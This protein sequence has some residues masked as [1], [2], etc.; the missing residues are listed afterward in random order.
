MRIP[1]YRGIQQKNSVT[2]Q[3]LTLKGD[4]ACARLLHEK[5][6]TAMYAMIAKNAKNRLYTKEAWGTDCG[7]AGKRSHVVLQRFNGVFV[8]VR[9]LAPSARAAT[10]TGAATAPSVLVVVKPIIAAFDSQRDPF[11][12]GVRDLVTGDAVNLLRGGAGNFHGCGAFFLRQVF[13]VDQANGLVFVHGKVYG[14]LIRRFICRGQKFAIPGQAADHAT[15]SGTWHMDLFLSESEAEAFFGLACKALQ[16]L[17]SLFNFGKFFFQSCFLRQQRLAA[18]RRR[19]P[20][21]PRTRAV[22]FAMVALMAFAMPLAMAVARVLAALPTAH[23]VA[24]A[25]VR[26]MPFQIVHRIPSFS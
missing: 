20:A 23:A 9:V 3:T 16:R 7:L 21:K 4:Y 8:N 10:A 15:F 5:N 24:A 12:Q 19:H 25:T 6:V 11:H 1:A 26:C 13:I 22:P 2:I 14:G 18:I 17:Q